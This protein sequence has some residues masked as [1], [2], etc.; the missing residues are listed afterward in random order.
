[1]WLINATG[2]FEL[3][4]YEINKLETE[5]DQINENEAPM[6]FSKAFADQKR[7]AATLTP[8]GDLKLW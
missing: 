8:D 7:F 6:R 5:E 2:D 3:K 1:M 4:A